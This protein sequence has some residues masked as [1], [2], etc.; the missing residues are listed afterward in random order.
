MGNPIPE[1]VA[2]INED[3]YEKYADTTF[4]SEIAL[5]YTTDGSAES[6]DLFGLQIWCSENEE[7]DFDES[8]NEYEDMETFL[9]HRLGL[10]FNLFNANCQCPCEN[11]ENKYEQYNHHET[12]VSVRSDLKGRHGE[13]CLCYSC[14]NFKPGKKDN[15]TIANAIYKNCVKF[16]LVTPVWECPD[17]VDRKI[18]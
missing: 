16:N 15:C 12:R 5:V 10:L 4:D 1:V 18:V 9:R 8:R 3:L 7:R 2:I 14:D 11:K 6:V 17:F 13:F